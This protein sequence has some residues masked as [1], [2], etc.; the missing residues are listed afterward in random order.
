VHGG[1]RAWTWPRPRRSARHP[2]CAVTLHQLGPWEPYRDLRRSEV[3]V[4][5]NW[6]A[7]DE[8]D[9]TAGPVIEYRDRVLAVGRAH[10][11]AARKSVSAEELADE[12]THDW[13]PGYPPA[14]GDAIHPRFTPSG[15]PIR[16]IHTSISSVEDLI[17]Q[18]ARGQI[19]HPTI[20]G[21]SAVPPSRHGAGPDHRP[22]AAAARAD[23]VYRPRKRPYPRPR[24]HGPVHPAPAPS[25]TQRRN[26]SD[27]PTQ[28]CPRVIASIGC[29]RRPELDIPRPPTAHARSCRRTAVQAPVSSPRRRGCRLTSRRRRGTCHRPAWPGLGRP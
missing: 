2:G 27:Q 21:V 17:T 1:S 14:L 16:R 23:L 18:V 24:S 8:P 6:L 12:I 15:R 10:R 7:V 5:I 4:V 28:P 25:G 9:L 29:Q 22:A 26:P 11:L 19:V 13:P 20:T 3:D